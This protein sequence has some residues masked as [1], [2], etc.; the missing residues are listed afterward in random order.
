MFEKIIRNLT[1]KQIFVKMVQINIFQI[2]MTKKLMFTSV[3][4]TEKE[5]LII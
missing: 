2:Q 4:R 5:M 1:L 3:A